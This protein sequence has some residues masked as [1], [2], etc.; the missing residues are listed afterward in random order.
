MQAM[1]ILVQ[2]RSKEQLTE[3]SSNPLGCSLH[4]QGIIRG[5][6]SRILIVCTGCDGREEAM[7]SGIKIKMLY[8]L[9]G[10]GL[11][12]WKVLSSHAPQGD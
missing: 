1:C 11:R 9:D 2:C 5:A 8:L 12:V 6:G 3:S 7:G 10:E 4:S